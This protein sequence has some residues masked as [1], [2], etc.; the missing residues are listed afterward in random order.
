MVRFTEWRE[1]EREETDEGRV[2][3]NEQEFF[4]LC[5]VLKLASSSE[6]DSLGG[7]VP[8]VAQVQRLGGKAFQILIL[9]LLTK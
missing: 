5:K 4:T 7:M 3:L 1:R 9:F 2:G 8:P 6:R